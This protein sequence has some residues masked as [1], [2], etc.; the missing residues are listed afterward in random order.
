MTKPFIAACVQMRSGLDRRRNVEMAADLIREAAGE[1][2]TFVATPEMTNVVDRD[3]DRLFSSIK[4]ESEAFEIE[5]FAAVAH[6]YR[7]W[8]LIGSMAI[9]TAERRAANRSFLY[10]P[11]GRVAARYD[12]IHRFDVELPGG[13]M[14]RE[15]NVY[16]AGDAAV[17]A[18]TPLAAFGLTICYD[19]RFPNLYRALAQAGA[20]ALCVPSA[21]TRQTG[22]AHWRMLL[23]ARAIENGAFVVAPAQGGV[24]EDGRAT[25]GHSMIVAPWGDVLAETRNAEPGVIVAEVDLQKSREA[26]RRIPNLALQATMPVRT[27]E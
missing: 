24:H 9:R 6:D 23:C 14:W 4:P 5:H 21:F 26:R 1:G 8:L 3:A 25:Y 15:S 13:E 17:L 18:K 7:I 22:E 11:D 10:A 27:F 20:E 12:K 2:A 19:L 16:D